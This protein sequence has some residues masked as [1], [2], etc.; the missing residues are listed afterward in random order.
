MALAETSDR[1][2][3]FCAL[4]WLA[5]LP[6]LAP[7][8]AV[9]QSF[10]IVDGQTETAPRTLLAPGDAGVIEAGGTLDVGASTAI[11]VGPGAVG[12]SVNNAGTISITGSAGINAMADGVAIT[13][14]G[15]ITT[16]GAEA[17]RSSGDNSVITSSG[18][19]TTVGANA[20]G[21]VA[22][23]SGLEIV[24]SGA[25]STTG[26]GALG[27]AAV[28][29]GA[30]ITMDGVIETTGG[31]AHGLTSGSAGGTITITGSI[32]TAGTDAIGLGSAGPGSTA[33]NSGTITA[34]GFFGIGVSLASSGVTFTNSGSVTTTNLV[35]DAILSISTGAEIVNSGII[36]TTG[37]GSRGIR[38]TGSGTTIRQSGTVSTVGA[39]AEALLSTGADLTIIQSGTV[40]TTG[41]TADGVRSTG[42]GTTVV[43]S[44]TISVI[45]IGSAAVTMSGAGSTIINGGLVS[46]TGPGSLAIRGGD[47]AQTVILEPGSRIVGAIDLAGGTDTLTVRG[48]N[49]SMELEVLNVER[50]TFGAGGAGFLTGTTVT[51]VDL[52]G[53]SFLG[54]TVASVTGAAHDAI[55]GLADLSAPA[56]GGF[57]ST[58]VPPL[59]AAGARV[60]GSAFGGALERDGR[61]G[62]LPFE[63]RYGGGIGGAE[64]AFGFG[65]LGLVAGLAFSRAETRAVSVETDAESYFAGAY[66]RFAAGP[67]TFTV[68]LLAGYEDYDNRRFVLNGGTGA[69]ETARA[70]F[71]NFFISPSLDV[72]GAFPLGGG[73]EVRPSASATYT[74]SFF[75][76]FAETG[77]TAANL[78]V[79]ARTVQTLRVRAGAAAAYVFEAGDLGGEV[80]LRG[81]MEGRL[82]DEGGIAASLAGASFRAPA[83]DDGSVLGGY[84]GLN[85]RLASRSGLS[86]ALDT[87]YRRAGGGERELAGSLILSVDF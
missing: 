79:G 29:S 12:A 11:T 24:H 72:A 55:A 22:S 16:V 7:A 69:V 70:D 18:T 33:V 39:N 71:G 20:R 80:S 32:T 40:L 45:G 36:L 85:L 81:G 82:G 43:Q 50:V 8:G 25:I 52:S 54:T 74:A 6:A 77:T 2:A 15:T 56:G 9:A 63:Q 17:I 30:N 58:A 31:A 73:F 42:A 44:G 5:C 46:A 19:I 14:S 10:V 84:V 28:G 76:G 4:I 57:S 83:I 51:R 78:S 1:R 49:L 66:G 67:L 60:W 62:M 23:G 34:T 86:L 53:L 13:S 48:G 59:G 3:I 41:E 65:E 75:Q 38:S 37:V 87:E 64:M 21:I 35:S 61:G 26:S 27:I 47:G 68:S